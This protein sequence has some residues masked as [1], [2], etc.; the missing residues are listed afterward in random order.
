[1][2]YLGISKGKYVEGFA[3]LPSID[4]SWMRLWDNDRYWDVTIGWLFW[5]VTIGQIHKKLKE[6]GYG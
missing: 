2:K 6:N 4:V 5:Y 1:M 3:V